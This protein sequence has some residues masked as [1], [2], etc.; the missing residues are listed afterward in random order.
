MLFYEV[1]GR[2]YRM[3]SRQML[4]ALA[5]KAGHPIPKDYHGTFVVQGV[6][7]TVL[8]SQGGAKHRIM[9]S[10][11]CGAFVPFGRLGQHEKG[12]AH[13]G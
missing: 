7:V 9:V 4:E 1:N 11:S 8:P 6:P 10:C 5:F 2:K 3:Q 12:K 13:K